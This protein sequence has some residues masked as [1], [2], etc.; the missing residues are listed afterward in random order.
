MTRYN[1]IVQAIA[2]IN[3]LHAEGVWKME[4]LDAINSVVVVE[5][6]RQAA[7]SPVA[8]PEHR[9]CGTCGLPGHNARTCWRRPRGNEVSP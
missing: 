9:K 4:G 8:R 5:M 3:A 2:T 6:L 1:K 7:A